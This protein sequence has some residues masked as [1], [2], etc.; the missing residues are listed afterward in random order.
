M[1]RESPDLWR[2][3][4]VFE[5]AQHGV[6]LFDPAGRIDAWNHAARAMT[7]FGEAQAVGRELAW[8]HALDEE[9]W[10]ADALERA[11]RGEVVLQLTRR[12]G[13]D[14]SQFWCQAVLHELRD[15]DGVFRGYAEAF[16]DVTTEKTTTDSLRAAPLLFD[17]AL[18][19]APIGLATQDPDLTYTWLPVGIGAL[20]GEGDGDV[21]GCTD[22]DVYPPDVAEHLIALKREVLDSGHG[23]RTELAVECDGD[24][25][26]YDLTLEPLRD[27]DEMVTGVSTVAFDVTD[28]KRAEE[29]IE[30]S[31]ARLAEAERVARLGSWEWD[32]VANSVEWSA[33]LREIYGV[34]EEDLGPS[35]EAPSE[36]VHPDDRE[37]V[38]A[39]VRRAVET[40]E[41]IDLEYRIVR[42]DGRVRRLRS[43]AEVI[44][45][46]AGR[47]LRLAGTAQDVTEVRATADAL[48][49]TAAELGRHAEDLR[50]LGRSPAAPAPDVTR[51][52]TA[53]QAEILALVAQGLSNAE[54]GERLFLSEGTVKWHLGNILRALGVANRAQ[55]V[56]RYLSTEPGR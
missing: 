40:C 18:R 52:L 10:P 13:A 25:R 7:G 9:R 6:A 33:G 31:W 34:S 45:D 43:R 19:N 27:P 46:T 50:G 2:F 51:R 36:L 32:L 26:H 42:P 8:L 14:G 39:A 11:A 56:A 5:L 20:G 37:R 15:E 53:R 21:I 24:M 30:R 55:A 29:Q 23:M 41:P 48:H 38:A 3:R 4:A 28:R 1:D 54:I 44:V 17:G 47:P 35:F 49:D 12:A 22:H 16:S